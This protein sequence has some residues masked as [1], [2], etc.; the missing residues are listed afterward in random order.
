MRSRIEAVDDR[1]EAHVYEED[2]A[3]LKAHAD[4][5][6][7]VRHENRQAGSEFKHVASIPAVIVMKYIADNGITFDDFMTDPKHVERLINDPSLAYFRT[8]EGRV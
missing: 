3:A 6:A 5:C 8:W 7:S 1:R 2:L 4:R